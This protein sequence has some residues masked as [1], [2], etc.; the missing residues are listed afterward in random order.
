MADDRNESGEGKEYAFTDEQKD[1]IAMLA[2]H[3]QYARQSKWTTF[4]EL[5]ARDKWPFFVQHF[6]IGT[7]AVIV[8]VAVA[9]SLVCTIVF[10]APDPE[11][12]VVGVNMNG[13]S[14]QLDMLKQRFVKD[15][16]IGDDRLVD[17]AGDLIISAEGSY[18]DDSAKMMAMV[19][20][21]QINMIVA[22]K[23]TFATLV[24]RD[25]VTS[26]NQV[27]HGEA[28]SKLGAAGA[29]V[30]KNGDPTDD[31]AEAYGL[32]LSKSATWTGIDG[33][34]S[35]AVIGFSNVTKSAD[36]AREFVTFL[37]FRE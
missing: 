5:P 25:Y 21:G 8:A 7:I 13:Y 12:S 28:L 9:V 3:N 34:P 24:G 11:L 23:T 31:A 35:D 33:L 29:F 30:D 17:V 1:A 2:S 15:R 20:A 14:Q 6:L 10:K 32:D 4:R 16:N 37:K 19:T 26:V 36:R 22:D 27:E 18:S